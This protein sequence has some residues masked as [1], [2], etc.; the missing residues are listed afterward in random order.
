MRA[1]QRDFDTIRK[2][3]AGMRS[4]TTTPDTRLADDPMKFNPA[5]V[6]SLRQL[7][8]AGLDPGRGAAP[9]H[10]RLRYFDP[11]R[12][13]AG[14]PEDTAALVETM[15]DDQITVTLVNIDQTT[16]RRIV[17]Q[18]G[19]YAEHQCLFVEHRNERADVGDSSFE[20][21]LAPG[22]GT[23]LIVKCNRHVNDPTFLFPWD[24]RQSTNGERRRHRHR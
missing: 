18:A 8:T 3:I 14:I 24:R 2:K 5:T 23:R 11:V 4:D 6:G 16:P 19:A 17:V 15:T 7:M 9:F 12:R 20:V 1:L 13:R 10:C 21:T 22:C